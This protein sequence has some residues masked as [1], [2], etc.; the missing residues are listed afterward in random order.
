MTFDARRKL[1]SAIIRNSLTKCR[2]PEVTEE[3]MI[4]VPS[5]DASSSDVLTESV[6]IESIPCSKSLTLWS[7]RSNHHSLDTVGGEIVLTPCL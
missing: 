4:S 7:K 2:K 1:L 3:G 5:K 6:K